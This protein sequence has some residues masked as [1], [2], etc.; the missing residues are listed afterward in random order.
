MLKVLLKN[1]NKNP[2]NALFS[3]KS[4]V[5]YILL[6]PSVLLLY[7]TVWRPMC[8][9]IIWSF[10]EMKGYTPGEFVG[11]DNYIRVLTD[12][13]FLTTLKNT[14]FYVVYSL[15][16]GFVLPIILAIFLNELVHMNGFIKVS[17]YMP[18]IMPSIA[19]S[20][21]WLL[22]FYPN[23][24]GLL[25]T[26]LMKFGLSEQQWLQNPSWTIALIIISVT[27]KGFGSTTIMYLASL[28][29]ISQELYEAAVIDGAGFLRRIFTITIPQIY[30]VIILF[31]IRQIISVVQIMEQPFAMTD[32]G[33]N[34]ASMSLAMQGYRYAF[35]YFKTDSALAV[36]VITFLLLI[37]FT[38]LYFFLNKRFNNEQ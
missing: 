9:G 38:V 13:Q 30:G 11:F 24:G 7:Y 10:F 14:V 15:L 18:S 23:S 8:T 28:Q 4:I 22:I 37:G 17:I 36:G 34:N 32:G 29:G 12:F 27:W 19:V 25:N 5:P 35:V 3:K 1:N 26:I 33:P 21:L 20:M 6:L 2:G 31:L 16:F